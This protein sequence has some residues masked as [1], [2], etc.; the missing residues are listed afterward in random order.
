MAS[1][2]I[3]SGLTYVKKD[4]VHQF[5]TP[6]FID[7][8]ELTSIFTVIPD[9]KTSKELLMISP[10]E[11]ITKGYQRGTSF[12]SSTGVV[13]TAKVLTVSRMKAQVEQTPDE[14][15]ATVYEQLIAKGVDANDV[16]NS[17]ELRAIII[18]AFMD[19][20]TRDIIR[21]GWFGDTAKE[22][23]TNTGGLYSPSGVL[24]EHYKEYLGFWQRIINGF[25][26]GDIPAAQRV[27]LNVVTTYQTVAAVAGVK[28]AT[29]TGT[30]GTAN[31]TINGTAYLATFATDLT[32]TAANF[33]TAHAAT[34]LARFGNCVVTSAGATVI[35]TAGYPGMNVTVSAP[36]NVSGDLAGSVA[37]TTAAVKNTTLVAGAAK[38]ILQALYEARTDELTEFDE[39]EARFDVTR[40][41]YENYLAY[42]QGLGTEM[43]HTTILNGK[44]SLTYNGIPVIKRADWDKRIVA[45][46]GGVMRHR[47]LLST[48]QN[49]VIGTDGTDDKAKVEAWYELKDQMNYFRAQYCMGTQYVHP[50]Y[51][52]AAY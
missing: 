45:D 26:S 50:V 43:A 21:Q 15:Y 19:G 13:I 4:L 46:F 22:T 30:S 25:T 16:E 51:I 5:F 1:L 10:L 34:I 23:M 32:T 6:L 38:N 40:S 29:I 7:N 20:M 44:P 33:V 42:L 18:E 49:Y 17:P 37:T 27:N 36:V 41:I 2:V 35:V 48:H 28:T 11:K 24:D 31:I 9:V 52:T 12:T 47:A 39:S 8:P 3:P 14:F